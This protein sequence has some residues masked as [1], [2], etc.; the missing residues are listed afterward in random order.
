M[1][2]LASAPKLCALYRFIIPA[3]PVAITRSTSWTFERIALRRAVAHRVANAKLANLDVI[4]KS[5]R[6]VHAIDEV[7]WARTLRWPCVGD[8][9]A[10]A[11][12]SLA[13]FGG[14]PLSGMATLISHY[15][16]GIS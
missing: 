4:M 9:C 3:E 6:Q 16:I 10:S 1:E 5:G 14:L 2:Q 12:V 11:R 8:C 13:V 7:H 15:R